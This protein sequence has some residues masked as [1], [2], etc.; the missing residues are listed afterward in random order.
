M[1]AVRPQDVAGS[2]VRDVSGSRDLLNPSKNRTQPVSTRRS[3]TVEL[4][5]LIPDRESVARTQGHVALG[6]ILDEENYLC[7][8]IITF[9]ADVDQPQ[10]RSRVEFR[11]G[12]VL[13]ADLFYC[14]G[15]SKV[16]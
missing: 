7:R 12:A 2:D 3:D 5:N 9:R 11:L 13:Q 10:L 6:V 1:T 8:T 16:L 4:P 14:H 15:H